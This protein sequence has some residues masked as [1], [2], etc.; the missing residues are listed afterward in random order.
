MYKDY[1]HETF[2]ETIS[3]K[4]KMHTYIHTYIHSHVQI[5][6]YKCIMTMSTKHSVIP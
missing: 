2:G 6:M 5:F 3:T 4:L 1:V